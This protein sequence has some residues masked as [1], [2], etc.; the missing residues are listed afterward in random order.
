MSAPA[1]NR[2]STAEARDR[3]AELVDRAGHGKE[4]LILTDSGKPLVAVVAVED[5]ELLEDL[6]DERD[7]ALLRERVAEWEAAGRPM[8]PLEE[9]ARKYGVDL[10]ENGR[11]PV[12][13]ASPHRKRPRPG[14]F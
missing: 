3:F 13:A 9:V 2:F 8:I 14:L 1:K 4:R 11:A 12:H 7:S 6:E 10:S 5:L